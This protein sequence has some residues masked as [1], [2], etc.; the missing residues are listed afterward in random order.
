MSVLQGR[1]GLAE[2]VCGS[3]RVSDPLLPA[4]R[5]HSVL[6]ISG[7]VIDVLILRV[8]VIMRVYYKSEAIDCIREDRGGNT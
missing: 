6:S 3:V 1:Q 4:R 7:C 5:S 8:P 2:V